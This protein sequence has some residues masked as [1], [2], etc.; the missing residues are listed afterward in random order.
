M[1]MPTPGGDRIK[2]LHD[3]AVAQLIKAHCERTDEPLILA[4]RYN[5][6]EPDDIHLLEVLDGFPGGED[7]ELMETEFERSANLMIMGKLHLVL[8]SP[9]QVRAAVA[10]GDKIVTAVSGGVVAHDDGGH[11]AAALKGTLGL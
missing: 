3:Q 10:R 4:V 8:G 6:D 9:A 1:A 5:Q 2:E 7:D 11:E